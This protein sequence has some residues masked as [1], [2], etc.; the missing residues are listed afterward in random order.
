MPGQFLSVKFKEKHVVGGGGG[1]GTIY[2]SKTERFILKKL[3]LGSY[4]GCIYMCNKYAD[5]R[6]HS[7][8]CKQAT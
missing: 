2:I 4:L 3:F 5:Q 6:E 7:Q 1:G 8:V